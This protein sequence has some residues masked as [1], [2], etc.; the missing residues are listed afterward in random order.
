MQGLTSAGELVDLCENGAK[1]A[2]TYKNLDN[3]V[4]GCIN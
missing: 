1:T 2:V 4:N 3:Y